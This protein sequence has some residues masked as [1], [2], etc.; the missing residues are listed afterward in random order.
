M[1]RAQAPGLRAPFLL[2]PV[3][4]RSQLLLRRRLRR[5]GAADVGN[6]VRELEQG[7]LRASLDRVEAE[8]R[9][10]LPGFEPGSVLPAEGALLY[11]LARA[12][13]PATVVETGTA[14]GISTAY[15]LAALDRN[16]TGRL[17]SID[18]PFEGGGAGDLRPLV[19]GTSIDGYDASPLPPGKE[20]GWA[21][22]EELR[23][24]WELRLGD[25]RGLLPALLA[26]VGE[27]E[28]FF[29]DSLHTREH[30][31]F[32]FETVWPRLARGGV[33]ASDDVFQ[34]KHDALPAFARSVGRPFSTFGN[35]GF[36]RK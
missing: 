13:R 34:R 14:S 17:V 28:L 35:L 3:H 20:P 4:R 8:Y 5:L 24:R 11:G 10:S 21:I 25:S 33:L 23:G 2:A 6:V 18:L 7:G 1:A 27:I 31:L 22:P 9:A 30:M 19:A 36:V 32:E 29:H 16:D 12:L 15:L 26:E